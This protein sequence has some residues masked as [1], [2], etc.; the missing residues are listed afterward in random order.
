MTTHYV[1]YPIPLTNKY[2]DQMLTKSQMGNKL[3]GLNRSVKAM[4]SNVQE[5]VINAIGYVIQDGNAGFLDR[6][7][8]A[9]GTGVNSTR[10]NRYIKEHGCVVWNKEK[11][12][13]TV[14]KNKRKEIT[15]SYEDTHAFMM[16]L[17]TEVEAW[18]VDPPKVEKE[19]KP[20]DVKVWGASQFKR[21][22]DQL[23]AM[24]K[25]LQAYRR[26]ETLKIAA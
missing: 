12:R 15:E 1:H 26:K 2:G 23:E 8:Q 3:A 9:T 10:L 19:E 6:L 4:K 20:F 21:H 13:F 7:V 16:H 22:P 5:L 25:E 17:F 14:N 18:H 11:G 24:I